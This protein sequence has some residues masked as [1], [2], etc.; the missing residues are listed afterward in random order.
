ME[1]AA[2]SLQLYVHCKYRDETGC[3]VVTA[4][5]L[6]NLGDS[7]ANILFCSTKNFRFD[8]NILRTVVAFERK[9]N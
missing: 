2:G 6:A 3:S 4:M 9:F 7:H 5:I 1:Y 8:S